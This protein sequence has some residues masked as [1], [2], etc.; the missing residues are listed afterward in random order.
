MKVEFFQNPALFWLPPTWTQCLNVA[1]TD[2][3]SSK[4]GNFCNS[5]S[6]K[7]LCTICTWFFLSPWCEYLPKEK[8][9]HVFYKHTPCKGVQLLVWNIH[10]GIWCPA[11]AAPSV[12]SHRHSQK[13]SNTWVLVNKNQTLRSLWILRDM[14][15][16]LPDI[17]SFFK[18]SFTANWNDLWDI[19][20]TV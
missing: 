7:S 19:K 6:K 11:P 16:L 20:L 5:I 14:W 4:Y 2:C 12:Y 18:L 15:V 8:T 17:K 9:L 13:V 10:K 1:T 3:F